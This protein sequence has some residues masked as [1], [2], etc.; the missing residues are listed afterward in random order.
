MDLWGAK[1]A[2]TVG[3]VWSISTLACTRYLNFFYHRE[4][5]HPCDSELCIFNQILSFFLHRIKWLIAVAEEWVCVGVV[6]IRCWR[7]D[8]ICPCVAG[9]Y[10]ELLAKTHTIHSAAA[11]CSISS[12][13]TGRAVVTSEAKREC[14]RLVVKVPRALKR[15]KGIFRLSLG[16]FPQRSSV[17]VFLFYN[18]WTWPGTKCHAKLGFSSPI[19]LLLFY[20]QF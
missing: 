2:T 4:W 12:W 1:W 10:R 13:T 6:H 14:I 18:E 9:Q 5:F 7:I 8:L 17:R 19:R 16:G 3:L 20:S 11:C 15:E